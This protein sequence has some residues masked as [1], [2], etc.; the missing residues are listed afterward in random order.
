[1][2]RILLRAL[3]R[4]SEAR[5]AKLAAK[6]NW[7]TRIAAGDGPSARGFQPV[8]MPQQVAGDMQKPLQVLDLKPNVAPSRDGSLEAG[9]VCAEH[10]VAFFP[11]H[12]RLARSPF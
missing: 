4:H 8:A 11:R 6:N 5:L 3:S 2:I 10:I 12:E 9:K 7:Q 1:V